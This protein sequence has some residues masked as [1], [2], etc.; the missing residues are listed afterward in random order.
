[1][2]PKVVSSVPT[3][4]TCPPPQPNSAPPVATTIRT[5]TWQQACDPPSFDLGFDSSQEENDERV[6]NLVVSPPKGGITPVNLNKTR[7]DEY[8]DEW[9][10]EMEKKAIEICKMVE[11]QKGLKEEAP[12]VAVEQQLDVHTP[13]TAANKVASCTDGSASNL[14]TS[15]A[16]KGSSDCPHA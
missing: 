3:R 7:F 9:N 2:Q 12:T 16:K 1:M 14:A 10:T 4:K 11:R 6:V 8:D 15:A 13:S 5:D